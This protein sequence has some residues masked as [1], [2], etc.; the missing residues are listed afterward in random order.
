L[1]PAEYGFEKA[2]CKTLLGGD[3]PK[4]ARIIHELLDGASEPKRDMVVLNAAAAFVAAGLDDDLRTAVARATNSLDS[5]KAREKLASLI[6]FTS[7]C[8]YFTR[9]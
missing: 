8:E 7:D 3:A 5:G 6:R 4:N 9:A 2:D 1:E